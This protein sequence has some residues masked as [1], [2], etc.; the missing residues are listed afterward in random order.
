MTAD[1]QSSRGKREG[2]IGYIQ[3]VIPAFD[4]PAYEGERYE[5]LVPDTL[6]L[7]E[8]AAL[9]VNVLT[10]ATDP[11]ADHELYFWVRFSS[12]PPMMRHDF[13]D[14]CVMKFMEALPLMRIASGSDLNSNVE[15]RWME[16]A[17]HQQGSDG[18][19]YVPTRGRPWAQVLT[20]D[21]FVPRDAG[22]KTDQHLY[23]VYCGRLLSALTLYYLRDGG[24]LWKETGRRMVDGLVDLA[25]DRGRYAYFSPI[26]TWAEKGST[27]DG[28]RRYPHLGAHAAFVLLGLVHFYRET[29][30]EPAKRLARKLVHYLV[31]EVAVFDSEG[32]FLPDTIDDPKFGQQ[33]HFHLHTYCLL[34][35]LEYVRVTGDES[36]LGLVLK[37][38]EYA[39]ANGNTLLGYFP[40]N[41]NVSEPQMSEM[42]EVA[43]MIALGLKLTDAG[44]GDYWDEV[45]RWA[46]NM[47]AEGQ[48]TNIDWIER[49][50]S[51]AEAVPDF[52]ETGDRVAE[53]NV[54]G[55]AGWPKANDWFGS[56]D[57][58]I[59]HCCTGNGTRA[60]YYLWDHILTH[61]DG[62]PHVNLLLNRASP[63]A[64]VDSHIPY[65][66]RVD[67]KVK[68]PL[69]L[70]IRIPEWVSPGEASCQVD[71]AERSLGWHG[72]YAQVGAVKPGD[73]AT[74]TFPIAERTDVVHVE[75]E[76][77][78]LTRKGN[79]VVSIDPPGRYC[80]LY[81]RSHYRDDAT[82]WRK[83]ER[84]VSKERVHW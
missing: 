27:D 43:D 17:L 2:T 62:K 14:I 66:G 19:A 61:H 67:V 47:F 50:P 26:P 24:P 36:P 16:V 34:S 28:G 49:L 15:R 22:G 58:G 64:D 37:G 5:A 18:L 13:S 44:V 20:L 70:S 59:M 81:Q 83:I 51:R 82:R 41:L 30:Y 38:Y 21:V 78:T 46:R 7:Q 77:Y 12:E 1:A 56:G 42:C 31:D 55:F 40:E 79:D 39:K 33:T 3:E 69:E 71:G 10:G 11:L 73:V 29:G 4:V 75:K 52:N 74:L 84:F 25:V 9:A 8:R 32:R 48:L 23:P 6:D 72:R 63:W 35:I 45:D 54:G 53:R 80:P 68:Q 57:M 76:T 65:T 60:I